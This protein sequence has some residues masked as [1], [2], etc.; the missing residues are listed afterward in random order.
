MN[1]CHFFIFITNIVKSNKIIEMYIRNFTIKIFSYQTSSLLKIRG[2]QKAT[3][4]P[5]KSIILSI[6]KNNQT[7]KIIYS[8]LLTL[9]SCN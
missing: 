8:I 1:E 7:N 2:G 9:L 3:N 6:Y 5:N 4:F